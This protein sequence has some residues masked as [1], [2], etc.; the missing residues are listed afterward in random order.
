MRN[1]LI[2]IRP[3]T[4]RQAQDRVSAA[5]GRDSGFHGLA[6]LGAC[7]NNVTDYVAYFIEPKMEH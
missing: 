4:L 7:T 6:G 1:R 5:I 2:T 3:L